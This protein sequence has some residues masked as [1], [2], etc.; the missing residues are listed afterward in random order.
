VRTYRSRFALADDVAGIV[1]IALVYS[2]HIDLA[3]WVPAP[4]SSA[5]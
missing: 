3:A 1:V 4:P 5:R 2:G